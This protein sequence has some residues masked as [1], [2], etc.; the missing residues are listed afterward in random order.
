MFFVS[1]IWDFNTKIGFFNFTY[2]MTAMGSHCSSLGHRQIS[3]PRH[4]GDLLVKGQ[5]YQVTWGDPER[6]P[7][8]L[9]LDVRGTSFPIFAP[10]IGVPQNGWFAMENSIQMDDLGVP[11]F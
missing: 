4:P 3:Y 2:S 1:E 9:V 6:L 11:L 5:R 8:G 10:K 7:S